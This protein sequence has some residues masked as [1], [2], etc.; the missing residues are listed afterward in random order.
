MEALGSSD[1]NLEILE[2]LSDDAIQEITESYDGFF[3]TVESLIAGTGDS[4]VED[5][6]VSHVYCLCKYGLDSLVRDHFLRSL[7]VLNI[8]VFLLD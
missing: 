6:F 3:T 1:C 4:L 8:N 5:E 7:E 2:T